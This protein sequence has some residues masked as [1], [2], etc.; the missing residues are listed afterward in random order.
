MGTLKAR[1]SEI[2]SQ[3]GE[4]VAELYDRYK[5]AKTAKLERQRASLK[6]KQLKIQGKKSLLEA[7]EAILV[8][9]MQ[10]IDRQLENLSDKC[11]DTSCFKE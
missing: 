1:L 11:K 5:A 9:K 3:V 8:Q 6:S 2:S 7:K 4:G 10:N